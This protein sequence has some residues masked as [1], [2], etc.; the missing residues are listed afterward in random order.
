VILVGDKE[1]LIQK[2]E[3]KDAQEIIDYLNKIGGESD[4]LSFGENEFQFTLQQEE[5]FIEKMKNSSS[6]MFLGRID[7]RLVCIVSINV[8]DKNRFSH[9]GEIAISMLK[10]FWGLGI[11]KHLMNRIID[12]AR[13]ETP[14]EILYL[15][16]RAD[17]SRAIKLYKRFGFAQTGY[18]TNHIKLNGEYFDEISM[19]LL[20]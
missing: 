16:V 4:Y 18:Y 12:Y 3:K 17:N 9:H 1:L 5:E 20:L 19:S 2:A 6:E 14:L 15:C 11:G 7:G 13:D 10:E 8:P